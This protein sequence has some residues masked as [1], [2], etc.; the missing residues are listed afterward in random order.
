[1]LDLI[2][3]DFKLYCPTEWSR[4]IN[5]KQVG[6]CEIY[7]TLDDGEVIAFDYKDKTIRFL[8]QDNNHMTEQECRHE[9][10]VRLRRLMYLEGFTQEGLSEATGISQTMLSKYITG[11]VCPSFTKV[12][13]ICKALRCSMDQ[14]RYVD[15]DTD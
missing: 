7:A 3:E 4:T 11:D 6:P 8:P 12:D 10:G 2:I 1:M 9:F 5:Y 14:L 15:E 13:K